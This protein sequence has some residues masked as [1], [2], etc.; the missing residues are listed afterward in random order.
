MGEEMRNEIYES[1]TAPIS[2]QSNIDGV[3]STSLIIRVTPEQKTMIETLAVKM[4][5][6]TSEWIRQAS[7]NP[8]LD[9]SRIERGLNELEQKDGLK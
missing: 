5:F 9:L 8:S 4:G 6:N 3:K 1:S 7:I 2:K